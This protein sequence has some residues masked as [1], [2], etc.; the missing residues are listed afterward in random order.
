MDALN[1]S[2][3]VTILMSYGVP[4]HLGM[5]HETLTHML[6]QVQ[7]QHGYYEPVDEAEELAM[8][9]PV[10]NMRSELRGFLEAHADVLLP[11]LGCDGNCHAHPDAQ[12]IFCHLNMKGELL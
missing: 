10:D 4:A 11:Q 7:Q 5:S 2:E 3:M 9:N 8:M 12:V 1:R 6:T